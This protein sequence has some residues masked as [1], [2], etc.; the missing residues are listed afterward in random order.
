MRVT[1]GGQLL[2]GTTS[3][4]FDDG[5]DNLIVG[6]GT[7]DNGITIFTGANVGD[8]GQYLAQLVMQKKV[9]SYAK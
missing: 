4:D 8:K 1:S 7:G 6:S 3:S 2:I 5:A 9:K